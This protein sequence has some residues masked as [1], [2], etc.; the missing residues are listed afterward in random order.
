MAGRVH[1]GTGRARPAKRTLRA[2]LH[3][4]GERRSFWDEARPIRPPVA[5]Q[6]P[7]DVDGSASAGS[8]P[9]PV[10]RRAGGAPGCAIP[11]H[12]R[13]MAKAHARRLRFVAGVLAG[14]EDELVPAEEPGFGSRRARRR[15][16]RL[17]V[18]AR[19]SSSS[20]VQRAGSARTRGCGDPSWKRGVT[21]RRGA[22]HPRRARTSGDLACASP[23]GP[24]GG[25]R[26]DGDR[27]RRAVHRRDRGELAQDAT[28]AAEPVLRDVDAGVG[29]DG[30]A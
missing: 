26:V 14:D 12:R 24:P 23:C 18:P 10:A 22:R 8:G 27:R 2:R 20:T 9:V 28:S 21:A 5:V 7:E 25:E 13:G 11:A 1:A 6:V 19:T 17:W 15:S 30:R 16:E 4:R 3:R 29:G